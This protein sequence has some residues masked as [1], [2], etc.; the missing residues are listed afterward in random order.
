MRGEEQHGDQWGWNGSGEVRHGVGGGYDRSFSFKLRGRGRDHQ[1]K[2][3][4]SWAG[5]AT[6]AEAEVGLSLT[7]AEQHGAAP[8]RMRLGTWDGEIGRR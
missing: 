1:A 8:E 4:R 3:G 7:S 5:G 2:S 6:G